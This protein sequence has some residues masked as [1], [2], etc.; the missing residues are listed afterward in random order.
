MSNQVQS[1]ANLIIHDLC[2]RV[3]RI[4]TKLSKLMNFL[5]CDPSLAEDEHPHKDAIK[6]LLSTAKTKKR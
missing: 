5:G 2:K 4:E 6:H 3:I 1:E